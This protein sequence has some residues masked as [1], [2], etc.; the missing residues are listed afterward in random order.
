MECDIMIRC[1]G[2][3]I[4]AD[5]IRFQG[6]INFYTYVSNN[7]MNWVDPMGLHGWGLFRG[8]FRI[9]PRSRYTPK[10]KPKESPKPNPKYEPTE[11]PC[12][13]DLGVPPDDMWWQQDPAS[14]KPKP[15][16]PNNPPKTKTPAHP[17]QDFGNPDEQKVF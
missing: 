5:P 2:R 10:P 1:I 12:P 16:N 13:E 11:P 14:P 4:T 3:F 6:G 8:R 17:Y 9:P 7:P 15:Y